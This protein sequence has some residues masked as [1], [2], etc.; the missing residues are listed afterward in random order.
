MLPGKAV[1]LAA[2]IFIGCRVGVLVGVIVGLAVP[3][4]SA[5]L[6]GDGVAVGFEV[7]LGTTIVALGNA[8]AASFVIFSPTVLHP[9]AIKIRINPIK[10][11]ALTLIRFL[12]LPI[13]R[14]M[15]DNYM[16]E[17]QL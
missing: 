9:P 16:F 5:V 6:L 13:N 12:I 7:T 1:S 15:L 14:I 4:G 17:F 11:P 3:V 8:V 2:R 10:I